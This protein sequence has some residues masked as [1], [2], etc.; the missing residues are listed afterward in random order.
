MTALKLVDDYYIQIDTGEYVWIDKDT[1]WGLMIHRAVLR[2]AQDFCTD[3]WDDCKCLDNPWFNIKKQNKPV[4]YRN[5]Y[6]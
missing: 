4:N 1:L 6:R 3:C 2:G 5:P